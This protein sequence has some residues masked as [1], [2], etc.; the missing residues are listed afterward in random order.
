VRP[1]STGSPG[2]YDGPSCL[3]WVT[4]YVQGPA[5]LIHAI[6]IRRG[7][8]V[9]TSSDRTADKSVNGA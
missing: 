9:P 7:A 8:F 1:G 2:G 5:V 3:S 6:T 4:N